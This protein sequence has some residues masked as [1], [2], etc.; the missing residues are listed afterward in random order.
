MK[1]V[2]WNI[3]L[4][5]TFISYAGFSQWWEYASESEQIQILWGFPFPMAKPSL[6]LDI[7]LLGGIANFLVY[8]TFWLLVCWLVIRWKGSFKLPPLFNYGLK[9]I[10]GI[11]FGSLVI[12]SV[13]PGNEIEWQRSFEMKVIDKGIIA[14]GYPLPFTEEKR[15]V[16]LF[17]NTHHSR[18]DLIHPT[19]N[20]VIKPTEKTA[21]NL[22]S[23]VK[24]K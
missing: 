10:A 21:E 6:G 12:F 1:K 13:N 7:F 22:H 11:H 9:I 8:L 18:P 16:L 4:P 14:Y 24:G 20:E 3:V 17:G 23:M 15:R 2:F 5:L 19:K